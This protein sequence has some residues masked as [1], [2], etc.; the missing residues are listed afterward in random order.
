MQTHRY[1]LEDIQYNQKEDVQFDARRYITSIFGFKVGSF[2]TFSPELLRR[3]RLH[4]FSS[5]F[6]SRHASFV[7][8][9]SSFQTHI[10][11]PSLRNRR[12]GEYSLSFHVPEAT[13]TQEGQENQDKLELLR[14]LKAQTD[15]YIDYGWTG[16]YSTCSMSIKHLVPTL[17]FHPYTIYQAPL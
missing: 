15:I 16:R 11:H 6:L 12:P 5:G 7:F 1:D 13:H 17:T 2:I 9:V 4:P 10:S 3:A 8:E 14:F